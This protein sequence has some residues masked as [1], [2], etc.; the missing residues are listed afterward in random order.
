MPSFII[1]GYVTDFRGGG[2]FLAPPPQSAKSPEKAH[3]EQGQVL[4]QFVKRLVNAMFN[5]NNHATLHFVVR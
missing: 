5:T 4:R 2:A 1:V 3:P